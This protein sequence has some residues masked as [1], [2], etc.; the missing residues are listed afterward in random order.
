MKTGSR[1]AN[2]FTAEKGGAQGEVAT[3]KGWRKD[4]ARPGKNC[5]RG[6]PCAPPF[7]QG[8]LISEFQYENVG[9]AFSS[10]GPH[11]TV[12]PTPRAK[13]RHHHGTTRVND[14]ESVP[15]PRAEVVIGANRV[16]LVS[17]LLRIFNSTGV[18][19]WGA[20]GTLR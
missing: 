7:W 3:R 5:K 11:H 1:P 9:G 19:R 14:D 16:K 18:S 13:G 4:G 17:D 15:A 2:R 10:R 8:F 6:G 12:V 20:K